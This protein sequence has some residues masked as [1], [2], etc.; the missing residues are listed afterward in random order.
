MSIPASSRYVQFVNKSGVCGEAAARRIWLLGTPSVV[1]WSTG[2]G[3]VFPP[4]GLNGCVKCLSKLSSWFPATT[5]LYL[6][7][8]WPEPTK[9]ASN[10]PK[11]TL[12]PAIYWSCLL[13]AALHTTWNRRREWKHLRQGYRISIVLLTCVY[14]SY[15]RHEPNQPQLVSTNDN[16]GG[17]LTWSGVTGFVGGFAWIRRIFCVFDICS[18]AAVG[19]FVNGW[20]GISIKFPQP[21]EKLI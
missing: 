11:Q 8:N 5:S 10:F 18:H 15:T 6:W 13:P 21:V 2:L 19:L 9:S 16:Q 17:K 14:R 20:T 7:G 12:Y 4:S 1:N 3:A